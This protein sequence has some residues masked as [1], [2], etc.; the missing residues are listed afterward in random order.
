MSDVEKV[1]IGFL[2]GAI[3]FPLGIVLLVWLGRW[4]DRRKSEKAD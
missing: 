4:M 2:L 3:S 1:I